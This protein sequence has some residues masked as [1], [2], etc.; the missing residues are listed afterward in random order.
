MIETVLQEIQQNSSHKEQ[1]FAH[2]PRFCTEYGFL[3]KMNGTVVST[4]PNLSPLEFLCPH[5]T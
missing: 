4:L 3:W 5:I 2:F 1:L